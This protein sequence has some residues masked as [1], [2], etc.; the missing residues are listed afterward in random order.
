MNP[1]LMKLAAL[2]SQKT[3]AI[4]LATTAIYF[5]FFFDS[6]ETLRKALDKLNNDVQAAQTAALKAQQA[7]KEVE[8]LRKLV[9]G[10]GE[11]FKMA[12]Q[13]LP[14]DLPMTEVIR[15]VDILAR[16]AGISIKSKQPVP[17]LVKE[18]DIVETIPLRVGL[19]GSYSEIVLFLYYLS[20]TERI[21]RLGDFDI[22]L[23][24]DPNGQAKKLTSN[25]E[26]LSYRF[27]GNQSKEGAKNK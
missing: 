6:G 26:V 5:M 8:D 11:Q 19:E 18:K 7:L 17:P 27:V 9:I 24:T 10:L 25:L 21:T 22:K 23:P 1:T 12:T 20:I 2:N 3:L 13:Q 14:T 15:T 16:S 4:A